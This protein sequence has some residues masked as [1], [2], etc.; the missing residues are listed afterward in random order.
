LRHL[1]LILHFG[2]QQAKNLFKIALGRPLNYPS[3]SSVT[4]D[5]DD[6]HIARQWLGNR[7]HW[8]DPEPVHEFENE[9]AKWNGSK[10]AFAFMAGR[11]ALSACI[12]ALG[13][14]PGD[15]AILPGYTCVVVPNAF[16]YEGIKVI[17]NDIELDTYGL[18]ASLIESK[19]T[20]NTKVILLP[21]H[22]GLVCRDYEKIIDIARR[23]G[24]F[25]IEDCCHGMGAEFKKRKIGNYGDVAFYSMEQSKII[26]TIQGG[27]AVTNNKLFAERIKE[28]YNSAAFPD[29]DLID[30][31][32]HC[33]M[34]NYYY[35]KHPQRWLIGDLYR[36]RYKDKII[37]TTT[38]EEMRG[39]KPRQYGTK[40]AAPFA[41]IA[42][43]QLKKIDKYNELRRQT[44]KKWDSWCEIHNYKKP[45]VI[46][47]STPVFL[48]Y[49]IMVEPEKKKN[50]TWAKKELAI[51]P[52]VWFKTNIHPINWPIA[53]CPNADNAVKQCINFPGLLL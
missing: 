47:E 12:Y 39:I 19:I 7:E 2:Y 8:Y 20:P 43:N 11:F 37:I 9:F 28:F 4:L 34:I 15:E 30:K 44:C 1:K 38:K 48:R 32:L 10:Y 5:L 3:L 41:A 31:Q 42:L 45:T 21:H 33:V 14:K 52:G 22:Y 27:I 24:L 29:E 35:Y 26:T 17:Y 23:H 13:L 51:V 40:M 36:L 16:I 53:G 49:P 50:T 25:V 46:P 18:D 6:L